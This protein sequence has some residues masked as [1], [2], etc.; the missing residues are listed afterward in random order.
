MLSGRAKKDY[1]CEAD[2]VATVNVPAG[3][4]LKLAKTKKVKADEDLAEAEGKE[5][6]SISPTARRR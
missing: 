5:K 2:A 6:L 4:E 3:G 1:A